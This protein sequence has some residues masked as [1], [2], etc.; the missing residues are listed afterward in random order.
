MFKL[1]NNSLSSVS[2]GSK[3]AVIETEITVPLIIDYIIDVL[4]HYTKFKSN[5]DLNLREYLN[6]VY[7][8]IVDIWG[9]ICAYYPMLELLSNNRLKLKETE[10]KILKQLEFIFNEYLYTPRHEPINITE[11]FAD[12]KSLGNFIYKY[13]HGKKK[14]STVSSPLASGIK[15]RKKRKQ[16]SSIFKRKKLI[17]KYQNPFFLSLK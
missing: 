5:G 11:L 17:K 3:A 6:E 10:L 14:T 16:T 9:F 15:T 1:Y 2:E 12:L 13:I 7:I 4:V 8:E